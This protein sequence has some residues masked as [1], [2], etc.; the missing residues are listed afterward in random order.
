[1]ISFPANTNIFVSHTPVSFGCGIDGMI[2][3]CRIILKQ[4]PMGQAYFMFINKGKEQLRVLWY[5]GQ[6]FSLCTKR[7]SKGQFLHWPKNTE[8]LCSIVSFFQAQILFSG[9]D[10]KVSKSKT[11][12]KK[13]T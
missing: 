2:R 11:I 7:S 10:V 5:D 3:Y 1:M 9:G 8:E 13:I 4:D 12:W 6:G